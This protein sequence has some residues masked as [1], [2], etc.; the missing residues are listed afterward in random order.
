M[1]IVIM[2]G[3]QCTYNTYKGVQS[4]Y[5]CPR[6]LWAVMLLPLLCFFAHSQNKSG[7]FAFLPFFALLLTHHACFLNIWRIPPHSMPL[8]PP[9]KCCW[10]ISLASFFSPQC[11]E[12]CQ[13][14]QVLCT[15]TVQHFLQAQGLCSV[16]ST[17]IF[18]SFR[19]CA[20]SFVILFGDKQ[21]VS[22]DSLQLWRF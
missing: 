9:P 2:E 17:N 3:R 16:S 10:I 5:A 22:L 11:Y 19:V 8:L 13:L 18:L 20:H 7:I 6:W 4:R 14:L 1:V 21:T 15:S 12:F